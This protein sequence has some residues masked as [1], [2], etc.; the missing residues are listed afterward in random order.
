MISDNIT[1]YG[2]TTNKE[3]TRKITSQ[4]SAPTGILYPLRKNQN[5]RSLGSIK[6]I[7]RTDLFSKAEGKELIS[8]ML[9]QLFMTR[10]GERVMLP[11]YGLD[12]EAFLFDPLDLALFEEMKDHILYTI[13]QYAK[14]I[15]VLNL[16]IYEASN[17]V[18][19]QG[20]IIYLTVKIRDNDL[21]PPFEVGINL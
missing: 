5:K 7:K 9:R 18:A 20:I 13:D 2:T 4:N 15:E 3:V 16:S 6:S 8:G 14:F 11:R 17:Y 12:M 10:P 19:N 1:R 21:I